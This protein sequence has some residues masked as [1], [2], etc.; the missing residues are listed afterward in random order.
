MWQIAS[1]VAVAVN[2]QPVAAFA[3]ADTLKADTQKAIQRLQANNID[4]YIMSG[5][6]P[7]VVQYIANQLGDSTCAR[8]Y[9]AAR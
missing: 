6:N 9:V 8:Q 4:V 7:N 1:I 5:D 3:L 2:E